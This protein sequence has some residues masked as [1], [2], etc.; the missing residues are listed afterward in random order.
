VYD[1]EITS[2][3]S[4]PLEGHRAE[5]HCTIRL[6]QITRIE[7]ISWF[8]N[9]VQ[10]ANN[11]NHR[12][13]ITTRHQPGDG[14]QWRSTLVLDPAHYSDSGIGVDAKTLK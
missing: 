7:S 5:F 10:L 11:V 1:A 12:T 9:S 6:Q 13:K 4:P 3:Q 8:I 14:G 2:S